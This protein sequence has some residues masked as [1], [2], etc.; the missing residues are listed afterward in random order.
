[1][2]LESSGKVRHGWEARGSG[3]QWN[4]GAD[5]PLAA[6]AESIWLRERLGGVHFREKTSMMV[7]VASGELGFEVSY[8]T[9]AKV[10]SLDRLLSQSCQSMINCLRATTDT[11][12]MLLLV[13]MPVHRR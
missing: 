5:A 8:T 12:V 2:R 3:W 7:D 4:V 13:D 6:Q 9:H 1:V 10:L 11:P